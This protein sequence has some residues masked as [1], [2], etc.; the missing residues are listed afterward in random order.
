MPTDHYTMTVMMIDHAV[1]TLGVIANLVLAVWGVRH[2][3]QVKRDLDKLN[4]GNGTDAHG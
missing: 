2:A 3:K 4:G 1:L